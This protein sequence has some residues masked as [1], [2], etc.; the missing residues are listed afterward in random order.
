MPRWPARNS[1]THKFCTGCKQEKQLEE[2][3][4]NS[5]GWAGRSSKCLECK[6][7][8]QVQLNRERPEYVKAGNLK[9]YGLE[10]HRYIQMLENQQGL[11]AICMQ[12]AT[13]QP[14]GVDHNHQTGKVRALLC[15]ECNSGLGYF[16]DKSELLEA[17]AKYLRSYEDA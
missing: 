17:A 8:Y 5:S 6:R 10:Y 15:A 7:A 9:K 2:F 13:Y 1:T 4:L 16:K 3:A 12:P 14:L 11:C